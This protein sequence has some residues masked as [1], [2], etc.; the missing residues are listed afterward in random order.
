[1]PVV[2]STGNPEKV[3]LVRLVEY[4]AVQLDEDNQTFVDM[5]VAAI[6]NVEEPTDI[7]MLVRGG[8]EKLR[9]RG[10]MWA[11]GEKYMLP[12]IL[13]GEYI[14]P[15]NSSLDG[16][17]VSPFEIKRVSSGVVR[18]Q[19]DGSLELPVKAYR[20]EGIEQEMLPSVDD[21]IYSIARFSIDGEGLVLVTLGYR[22]RVGVRRDIHDEVDVSFDGYERVIEV[23]DRRVRESGIEGAN[24]WEGTHRGEF[25][26]SRLMD[27]MQSLLEIRH[28]LVISAPNGATIYPGGSLTFF[29]VGKEGERSGHLN[30]PNDNFTSVAYL[31]LMEGGGVSAKIAKPGCFGRP[32]S[33]GP[34]YSMRP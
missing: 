22:T 17:S 25:E 10:H 11:P 5:T 19:I 27:Q 33:D 1:M 18:A 20:L 29:G 34:A 7:S 21:P 2:L 15:G 24:P 14:G 26:Y 30:S 3:T 9:D 28:L 12:A 6:L 32:I 16:L 23:I 8:P 13:G 4:A 31:D